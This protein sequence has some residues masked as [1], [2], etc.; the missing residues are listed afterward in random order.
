MTPSVLAM[1]DAFRK[2][3]AVCGRGRAVREYMD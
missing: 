1:K 3:K 2:F